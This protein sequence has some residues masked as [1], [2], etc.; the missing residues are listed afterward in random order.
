ME[1]QDAERRAFDGMTYRQWLI[2][3]LCTGMGQCVSEYRVEETS[4]RRLIL[5]ANIVAFANEIIEKI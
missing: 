3:Q 4:E 1:K 5:A 2:G